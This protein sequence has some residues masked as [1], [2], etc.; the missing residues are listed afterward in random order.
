MKIPSHLIPVLQQALNATL[1]LDPGVQEILLELDQKVVQIQ[2]R[3]LDITVF[4][5]V[6]DGMVEV[7]GFFDG[8]VDS[9]VSG[10][11]FALGRLAHDTHGM[12]KGDVEIQGST[13][14]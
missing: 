6:V 7:S 13:L 3:G 9:T 14:R 1:G 11:P 12:F 4:L 5:I 8:E 10:T 2:I